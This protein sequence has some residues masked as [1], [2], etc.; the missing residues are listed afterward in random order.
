MTDGGEGLAPE[1]LP[2]LF[3]RHAGTGGD[4]NGR[5]GSGLGLVICRGLVEAHGGR[6]RAE[7]AGLARGTTVLDRVFVRIG[8]CSGIT[9]WCSLHS[10]VVMRTCEP[11]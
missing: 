1:R 3:R 4:G 10:W 5:G 9:S 2:H 7:S 8:S 6:I 11:R